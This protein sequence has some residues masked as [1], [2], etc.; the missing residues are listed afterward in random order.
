MVVYEHFQILHTNEVGITNVPLQFIV[1]ESFEQSNA[2]YTN[3]SQDVT[4]G[5]E[6][7]K[8]VL[9]TA[10][11]LLSSNVILKIQYLLPMVTEHP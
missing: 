11:Q 5:L 10:W 7:P 8:P 9:I 4:P 2:A 6:P 3:W 1:F